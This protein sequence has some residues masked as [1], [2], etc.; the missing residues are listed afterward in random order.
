MEYTDTE[1]QVLALME[2]TDFKNLSK[3]DV[4]S[5]ASKLNELRPEVAVQ[6]LAQFPELARL[7]QSSLAE[8]KDILEKIVASD[9][10][11]INQV[12]GILNKELDIADR[13]REEYYEFANKVRLDLSKCLDNPNS[14]PEQQKEIREQ[15]MEI[16]RMVDKKDSEIRGQE[17]ETAH[18]ADSKDSEKRGFN[19]KVISAASFAVLTAVGIGAAT[20]GGNF[21]VKLPKK[22]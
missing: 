5:Y 18:I 9:D 19:W 1:K 20:L 6:V 12:Y 10:E 16:L 17:T 7:I 8:Y 3:N 22:S 13:S 14:T 15:E 21:N 11:S 4:I 2:R